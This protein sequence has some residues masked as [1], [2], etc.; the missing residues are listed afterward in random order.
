MKKSKLIE[1]LNRLD[2]LASIASA[3]NDN[4]EAQQQV[5]DYKLLFD[6]IEKA[7]AKPKGIKIEIPFTYADAEELQSAENGV[8][9]DWTFDGIN[10]IITKED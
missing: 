3:D 7:S 2:E 6:F 8:V 4:G 9:F 5:K 1:A 10:T